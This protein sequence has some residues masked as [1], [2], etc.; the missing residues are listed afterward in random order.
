VYDR[1]GHVLLPWLRR[2]RNA[3]ARV[4]TSGSSTAAGGGVQDKL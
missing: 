1:S 3:R 4:L 2:M